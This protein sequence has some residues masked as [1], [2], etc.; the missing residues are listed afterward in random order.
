MLVRLRK[1]NCKLRF[2]A[3]ARVRKR[4]SPDSGGQQGIP[5]CSK[6]F[7]VVTVYIYGVIFQTFDDVMTQG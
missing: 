6:Y 7:C 4:V 1:L 5:M 2:S 3:M